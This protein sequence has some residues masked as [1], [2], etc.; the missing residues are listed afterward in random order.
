[1]VRLVDS[2]LF[3]GWCRRH[4]FELH[5]LAT[6]KPI[7]FLDSWRSRL[8][9]CRDLDCYEM[10]ITPPNQ[11]VKLQLCGFPQHVDNLWKRWV[12]LIVVVVAD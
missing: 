4:L 12:C 5:E 8:R 3:I 7:E 10:A 6:G 9:S 11:T 2:G 1:M